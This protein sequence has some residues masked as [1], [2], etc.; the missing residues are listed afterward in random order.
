VGR[1]TV[2]F[3]RMGLAIG[4]P[5]VLAAFAPPLIQLFD[6]GGPPV[7]DPASRPAQRFLVAGE[8]GA[9][10]DRVDPSLLPESNG[11]TYGIKFDTDGRE[12]FLTAQKETMLAAALE[13]FSAEER[14][15]GKLFQPTDMPIWIGEVKVEYKPENR[16]PSSY[17]VSH[18]K[19]SFDWSMV[20]LS[21]LLLAAAGFVYAIARAI[22][23]IIE[24][25]VGGDRRFKP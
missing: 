17:M 24:G 4:V 21:A 22:A 14:R 11:K 6:P 25:F 3:H 16:M 10:I 9:S 13:D 2:G 1:V 15:R 8:P 18:L 23:W 5:F 12:L 7:P 19:R 20:G